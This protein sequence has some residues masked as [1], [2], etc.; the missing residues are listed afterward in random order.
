[1][2]TK[3]AHSGPQFVRYFEPILLALQRL[4]GSARPTEATDQVARD[5]KITDDERAVPN[6]NGH[7]RFDNAV[8]WARLY[9]AK[10]GYIDHLKI[11]DAFYEPADVRVA[12]LDN[13]GDTPARFAAFY[14]LGQDEHELIRIIST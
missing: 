11:G 7:S 10:A 6:Q 13:E 5:L 12:R 3:N 4:G 1:M 8:A 2:A 14:L 9:L